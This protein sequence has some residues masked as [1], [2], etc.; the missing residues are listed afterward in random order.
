[1]LA[2][3]QVPRKERNETNDTQKLI[4]T[5]GAATKSPLGEGVIGFVAEKMFWD[6]WHPNLNPKTSL[7]TGI[8][9]CAGYMQTTH[10][11]IFIAA[12]CYCIAACMHFI[13]SRCSLLPVS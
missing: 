6:S 12:Q 3:Q 13:C 11:I 7:I 5:R 1:M 4:E 8:S 10:T 2:Q 9:T